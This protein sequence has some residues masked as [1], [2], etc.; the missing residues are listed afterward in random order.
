MCFDS[1]GDPEASDNHL[2]IKVYRR[3]KEKNGILWYGLL[4]LRCSGVIVR[5]MSPNHGNCG[6]HY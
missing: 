4:N 6:I 2:V 5:K 3:F 1:N